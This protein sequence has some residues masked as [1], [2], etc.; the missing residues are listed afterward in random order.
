MGSCIGKRAKITV[1]GIEQ[2][3]N[4]VVN[5]IVLDR[6]TEP[7]V[8]LLSSRFNQYKGVQ[9]IDKKGFTQIFPGINNFPHA[10][11]SRCFSIFD[12]FGYGIISFR[13][14]CVGLAQ[15]LLANKEEKADFIYKIYDIDRDG[16]L[17]ENEYELFIKSASENECLRNLSKN[18]SEN[19]SLHKEKL[20]PAPL[21]K[22]VFVVWALRNLE[23]DL[24][25]RPFEI[26]PS[27]HTE[28]DVITKL[29]TEVLEVGETVFLISSQWWEVWK[30][31]VNFENEEANIEESNNEFGS[32]SPV[33]RQKTVAFGDKPVG[34]DNS[35]LL[36][37]DS[38]F[39]LKP[40][41][42]YKRDFIWLKPKAWES[43]FS[44]YGGGPPIARKIILDREKPKIELFPILV[45][46][47]PVSKQGQ[48][49]KEH[50]KSLLASKNDK[51][52]MFM[53]AACKLFN[54]QADNSRIWIKS[55]ENWEVADLN[56]TFTE[57]RQLEDCEILLETATNEKNSKTWP[58]DCIK[59]EEELKAGDIVHVRRGSNSSIDGIILNIQEDRVTVKVADKTENVPISEITSARSSNSKP[60]QVQT[61]IPGIVGL[62][63]V[64]NTCYINCIIQS[65][66]H[67][68]LLKTFLSSEAILSQIHTERD[69]E[70]GKVTLEL[71]TIIR[72]MW[73]QRALKISPSKFI[74]AFTKIYSI[75]EGNMQHDCHEF[76]SL[77]M[78]RL[79][80]DL[81]R[82]GDEVANKT[83]VVENP[84][85]K[86]TE[87]R[88]A[89]EQW[90]KLQGNQG[91]VITDLCGGQT[92]TTLR[93]S[94][95]KSKR[96]LFEI[97]TNLSLPIPISM[98]IPLY[99]TVIPLKGAI[100]M[101]GIMISKYVQVDDLLAEISEM[102]KINK[103]SLYLA[104][105]SNKSQ[106]SHFDSHKNEI[107]VRLGITTR[108][109]LYAYEVIRTVQEAE[110]IGGKKVLP[111]QVQGI[112]DFR[113]G[114]QV[115]IETAHGWGTGRIKDIRQVNGKFEYLII[116]DLEI[117]RSDWVLHSQVAQFRSHTKPDNP[118]TLQILLANT[119]IVNGV[120][121]PIGMPFILSIGNWYTLADLFDLAIK[122]ACRLFKREYEHELRGNRN[123]NDFFQL[124]IIDPATLGCGNCRKCSG[125]PLPRN[126][127]DVKVFGT[128]MQRVGLALDWNQRYFSGEIKEHR[129]FKEVRAKEEQLFQPIDIS[130]CLKAF[131]EEEKLD[132]S[133]EKCGEKEMKMHMEI[134]RT[135][136]ILILSLK[137]FSYQDGCLE[138]IDQDVSFPIF[139][140]D[141][142]EWVKG[143]ES[144]NG[145]TLSTTALQNAY[146]LYAIV[147][148]SGSITG[149]HYTA[150][151]QNYE[152]EEQKWFH[153]DDDYVFELV[154]GTEDSIPIRN[155]YMLFYRRRKFSS[156]NVINLAYQCG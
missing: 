79:H 116:F 20:G 60:S 16:V 119:A 156:S 43:L 147:Y 117:L 114:D 28:R 21:I 140:F 42:K 24:L 83:I 77:F 2:K 85:D 153:F 118:S 94:S 76:L 88:E 35:N 103:E 108:S 40:T 151:C 19:I 113:I 50:K 15:V 139:A 54:V 89:D 64:G 63:N 11:I 126:K 13:S 4:Y 61:P 141:I 12:D 37:H 135:P 38:K 18:P 93:C 68:P 150:T 104:E 142:S 136:D 58:R 99:I 90:R 55:G 44:W 107:L 56:L 25:L 91:S 87:I 74:K 130:L 131:T 80:E 69:A 41:I 75:F 100:Q 92:R 9:G 33:N 31:Y 32:I 10:V 49:A 112:N 105:L 36:L 125:C 1:R 14:F 78:D 144:S 23:L 121:E 124:V 34:I 26:I 53:E 123:I 84:I 45:A 22:E 86:F 102:S 149:G 39:K 72:E 97:F 101:I 152:S 71:A 129:S 133:C 29:L 146:D 48:I 106:L 109:N 65:L 30:N 155:A 46:I 138:K 6:W 57:A 7:Q 120:R 52:S 143:I 96:V 67:T 27:A 66:S 111:P 137:R 81:I 132:G 51:I 82:I 70:K 154:D 73:S 95:C 122:N 115:D 47:I 59:I 3:S 17:K 148:H 8:K 5:N 128:N 127:S 110:T 134:W 145:L 98:S 62:I